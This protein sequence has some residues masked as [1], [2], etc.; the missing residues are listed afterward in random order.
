MSSF[1]ESMSYR[2]E[3]L[4]RL[5]DGG[6]SVD[7]ALNRRQ[8]PSNAVER[9]PAL[10]EIEASYYG[11]S[12]PT[13]GGGAPV[14]GAGPGGAG[15]VHDLA[16]SLKSANFMPVGSP[17]CPS[18]GAGGDPAALSS[19]LSSR[20]KQAN[21]GS[22]SGF[23]PVFS[24]LP[25]IRPAALERD[26]PEVQSIRRKLLRGSHVLIF[27]AGYSGK[28]FIYEH[29]NNLGVKM[30][31]LDGPES[32]TK[33]LVEDGVIES[34][35]E[36]DFTD[37]GTLFERAMDAILDT[38]ISFDGVCTFYEDAVAIMARIAEALGL[39]GNPVEACD[40]ARNKRI[41]REIMRDSGLPA[42]KFVRID[43]EEQLD[44]AAEHVG[45]PAI[46]KPVFGAA[47]LG[48]FK[49]CS[50]DELKH[51]YTKTRGTMD[52]HLDAIWTQGSEM[53]VEEF[54]DGQEFDCDILMSHG[55]VVYHA[56]SDNW[57]CWEPWYQE[58]G[59][60]LP[61]LYPAER[62]EELV[63]LATRTLHALG[64]KEGAFHV[65]LKYTSRGPRI[66]EVNARMGGMCVR[67]A[68]LSVWGVDIVE[69]HV[70]TTLGIPIRPPKSKKPLTAF[71]QTAVNAPYSGVVDSDE[72]L[73]PLAKV[74]QCVVRRLLKK[75]GDEVTGPD[76]GLPDWVAEIIFKGDTV[77][78]V[79][80]AI[81]D[82]IATLS[83]PITADN[84]AAVRGWFFPDEFYPFVPLKTGAVAVDGAKAAGAV[85]A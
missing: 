22:P 65:E 19:S 33:Q 63:D 24:N 43:S 23:S 68:N 48:V 62:Q 15:S 16:R 67:D 46:L 4:Q 74:P 47:S 34:Y 58:T 82:A 21:I 36:L 56:L 41:T 75:K 38:G 20:L 13:G 6:E 79:L 59:T 30:T 80:S 42:P 83:V 72:W 32:W 31:I 11:S 60:N 7:F 52:A 51:T 12:A 28:R 61:S 85:P 17:V 70:M 9:V 35:I 54:Y 2:Q 64:F 26:A 77:H 49:V 50:P 25:S 29:L 14:F 71:L 55:Q 69:E 66:I 76:V 39:P 18:S 40:R 78:E 45:F 8:M 5:R 37:Y 3:E 27:Q 57:M 73:E 10:S 81:K 84:P 1:T 44:A 53:V